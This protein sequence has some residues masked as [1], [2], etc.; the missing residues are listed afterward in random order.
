MPSP[1]AAAGRATGERAHAEA[2]VRNPQGIHLRPATSLVQA[3][4][5][6]GC[7]VTLELE[8]GRTANGASV[9]ELALLA[10]GH[11]SRLRLT[12]EGPN[13]ESVAADL[14]TLLGRESPE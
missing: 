6:S 9:L 7:A 4:G 8:D 5:E 2:V 10:I 13:A 11:G 3:V 14:V 1:D 12:V